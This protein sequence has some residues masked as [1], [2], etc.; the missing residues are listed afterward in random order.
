MATRTRLI[1][2]GRR[3]PF[4]ADT[5]LAIVIT[6]LTIIG[7][8]QSVAPTDA[9][10]KPT[11]W[12]T[13]AL[14][15][16]ACLAIAWRRR[17]PLAVLL[18]SLT[19]VVAGDVLHFTES[20]AQLAPIIAAYTVGAHTEARRRLLWIAGTV[21][22]G[23]AVFNLLGA[24]IRARP[25]LVA[26][27]VS[28]TIVFGTAF[29]LGDNIRRRRQRLAE[30]EH[31]NAALKRERDLQSANA[32]AAERARIARELHDVVAHSVS[33]IAIQAGG[34]RRLIHTKPD[35]AVEALSVIETSARQTLD[36]LRRLLGVLR[37]D[38]SDAA[39]DTA[40]QPRLADLDH[41]LLADPALP[42]TYHVEGDPVTLPAV[43][44]LAAYRIVQEALTN[45]RKHAGPT[46]AE[47]TVRYSLRDIAIDVADDGWGA[48][49]DPTDPGHGLTGMRE[50]AALCGG[51][52][53]A[54]PRPGGGWH[55]HAL[56]PIGTAS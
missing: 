13:Y 27:T 17:W 5:A 18:V 38:G 35:R 9:T 1:S 43:V 10:T 7:L 23:L 2:W 30:L 20:A 42:V 50:R 54:G 16:A 14:A 12:L 4:H 3:H 49:A 24:I 48:A 56:L 51:T 52:V 44:E 6:A 21:I 40:P 15:S 29:L 26:I 34:A 19:L 25:E 28:N 47:V 45:V 46:C 11:T 8:A 55:V 32:V 22:G 53:T 37:V 36:E 41:L 31:Q 33:V 39:T